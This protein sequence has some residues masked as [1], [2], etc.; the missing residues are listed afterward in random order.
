MPQGLA[1]ATSVG[2]HGNELGSH[3]LNWTQFVGKAEE[4]WGK[5]TDD[6]WTVS[7]GKRDQLID[8]LQE[9]DGMREKSPSAN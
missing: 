2:R 4:Q 6:D 9:R 1:N 3:R 5:L 8:K 7:A